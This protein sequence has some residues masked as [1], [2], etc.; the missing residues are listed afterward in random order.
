[1]KFELESN[2]NEDIEISIV[3][4]QQQEYK[5]LG[6]YSK[7]ID[8]GKIWE[9]NIDTKELKLA[10]FRYSEIYIIGSCENKKLDVKKNCIYVEAINRNN[11]IK[12]L[13]NGKFAFIS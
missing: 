13:R 3:K 1:M 8:G 4:K 5:L 11:A 10:E 2:I 9:Y 7:R 6:K 12:H